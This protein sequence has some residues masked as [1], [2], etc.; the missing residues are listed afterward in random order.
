M[1]DDLRTLATL[2]AA[3]EPSD[4]T[5]GRGRGQL[6]EAIRTPAGRCRAAA[7]GRGSRR[8]V[9]WLA[10]GFGLAAAATALFV[11][12]NREHTRRSPRNP[13]VTGGAGATRQEGQRILLAAAIS[14]AAQPSGT[15]WHSKI[16]ITMTGPPGPGNG[17]IDET[18]TD[19][20]GRYW[21]PSPP[22]AR[23]RRA[24]SPRDPET[25]GSSMRSAIC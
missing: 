3:P 15:Y 23:Y 11:C 7:R 17:E 24:W 18:W 21:A 5:I 1:D 2:L 10:G 16:Q 9:G 19:H 8:P 4:A 6:V 22:A 14:A 20:D 13:P 25:A 12:F